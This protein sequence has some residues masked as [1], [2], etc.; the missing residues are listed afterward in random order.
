MNLLNLHYFN[1][2]EFNAILF[3]FYCLSLHFKPL[4]CKAK[5]WNKSY[6]ITFNIYKYLSLKDKSQ[7]QNNSLV[8]L[9]LIIILTL[10]YCFIVV[11]GSFFYLDKTTQKGT[12]IIL[13]VAKLI[14]S[15]ATSYILYLTSPDGRDKSM[16]SL[17]DK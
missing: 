7:L 5:Q 1:N 16:I 13:M 14:T 4:K 10:I 8:V 15:T 17:F 9:M 2:I 11:R 6:C 12:A 3:V